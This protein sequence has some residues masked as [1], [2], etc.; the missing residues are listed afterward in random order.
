MTFKT[1]AK[2][3]YKDV[4]VRE[5]GNGFA[6]LLDG[7]TIKTPA[8]AVM[9]APTR[10]LGDAIAAEWQ[11]QGETLLAETMP[12]TKAL[13]TALDRVAANRAALVDDLAKYAGSDLLCYRAATPAELVRRQREAW[14]P[15]LAWALQVFGVRLEV[16]TG[17]THVAQS[18]PA[19]A[20]IRRA[21][22]TH[23]DHR[24]V[25]LHAGITI[26]GSALLGLAFAAGAISAEEA[27]AAAEVDATYQ[28]E[29]WGR[30][31]EAEKARANRTA[32]LKAA[33]AYL[34]LLS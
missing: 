10:R 8:G 16:T 19:L 33:E 27:L 17:V 2:R 7:R 34:K 12:L 11:G 4:A 3:F 14:D 1:G 21:I 13:N 22:E 5:E 15:W 23:D 29:L 30:D 9:L 24:L 28:A 20:A 25:A 6:V 26:T 32:D 18:D 31:T